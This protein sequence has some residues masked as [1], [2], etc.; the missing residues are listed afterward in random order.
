MKWKFEN[1]ITII[2][3]AKQVLIC[4]AIQ[5]SE[6]IYNNLTRFRKTLFFEMMRTDISKLERIC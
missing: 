1:E 6:I 3:K 4:V 5:E 2:G